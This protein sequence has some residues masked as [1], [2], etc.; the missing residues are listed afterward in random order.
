MTPESLL[1]RATA[2]QEM[3]YDALERGTPPD[4]LEILRLRMEIVELKALAT[5]LGESHAS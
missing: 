2:T 3:L 1:H 4:S 5:S